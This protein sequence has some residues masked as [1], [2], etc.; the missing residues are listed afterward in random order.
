[1]HGFALSSSLNAV[2]QARSDVTNAVNNPLSFNDR[3]VLSQMTIFPILG[4]MLFHCPRCSFWMGVLEKHL[5]PSYWH[6]LDQPRHANLMCSI[7]HLMEC[8]IENRDYP[9]ANLRSCH[10]PLETCALGW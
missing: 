8:A 5:P 3:C 7:S 4:G 2:L 1:M 6:R 10:P 9:L